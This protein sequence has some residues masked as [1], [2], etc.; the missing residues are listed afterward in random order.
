MDKVKFKKKLK[1]VISDFHIGTG[2]EKGRFN[3]FEDFY[4]DEKFFEFLD[5]YSR[6]LY[7][8]WE[9]ELIINGDFFD[10]LKVK[11]DG[12]WPEEITE[13]I[14]VAKLKQCILS[15]PILCKAL[16]TFLLREKKSL[17][18]I[19]GNHDI[20]FMYPKVQS[21][22]IDHIGGDAIRSKVKFL[23]E[24]DTYYLPEG[25]Q[26][27]HGH[28]F[29]P[30][31]R[32]DYKSIFLEKGLEAPI[33]NLPWGSFFVLKVLNPF[34]EKRHHIDHIRPFKRF[35]L[36]GL[37]FDFWFTVRLILKSIYYFIS[38]RFFKSLKRRSRLRTTLQILRKEV[39]PFP[40]LEVSAERVLK[41]VQG[42]HTI[43]MGHSHQHKC[44]LFSNNKLYI[45][46]GTWT[47][48]I[49]LNLQHLGESMCLTYAI[50][51]YPLKGEC[52]VS[53]MK[54]LGTREPYQMVYY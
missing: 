20:E 14:A 5:Y 32:F 21:L 39:F 8:D 40:N 22:F 24:T 44:R 2:Q 6:G 28:Q 7:A 31:H 11:V 3:P 33:L 26:I 45:N 9:V 35:I 50:I 48:M 25:I 1:L 15:H 47:R 16:K 30:N 18:F 53:L 37:V 42:V 38:T 27:A 23:T 12:R 51:K 54:W 4:F 17:V 52:Q 41:K 46:T 36:G 13:E 43:I 10:L 19:P 34:K 49:N 29:E